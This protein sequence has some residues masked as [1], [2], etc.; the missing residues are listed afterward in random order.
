MVEFDR[1]RD[2]LVRD[3]PELRDRPELV[4]GFSL[5]RYAY[6]GT[7]QYPVPDEEG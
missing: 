3:F 6:N 2:N 7:S 5:R 1:L 4:S